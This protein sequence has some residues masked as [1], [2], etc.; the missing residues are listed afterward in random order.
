LAE[1]AQLVLDGGEGGKQVGD[2]EALLSHQPGKEVG[3]V[4]QGAEETLGFLGA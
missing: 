4:L 1:D 2:L 3:R